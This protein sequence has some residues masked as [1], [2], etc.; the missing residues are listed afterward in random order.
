MG[1]LVIIKQ[2]LVIAILV[3][4]GYTLFRL[5]IIDEPMSKKLSTLVIDVCNPALAIACIIQDRPVVEHSKILFAGGIGIVIYLVLIAMG[6]CLPAI[7]RIAPDERKYYHMMM[8]YTNTGFIGIPLARAILPAEAMIYVIIFNVLFSLFFYTHG[9]YVLRSDALKRNHKNESEA[10][11]KKVIEDQSE[12]EDKTEKEDQS[13][14]ENKKVIAKHAI[15]SATK[16]ARKINIGIISSLIAIL[17]C[18]FN[19]RVP[20]VIGDSLIYIANA[21]TFLSMTV[22]GVS[23]AMVSFKDIFR[24]KIVYAYALLHLIVIPIII[25]KAM[26]TIGADHSMTNAFVLMTALPGANMPLMLAGKNGHDTRLLSQMILLTT[27]LSLI[28]VPAVMYTL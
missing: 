21:T 26:S 25:G 15:K 12:T 11:D 13:E 7:L 10:E 18:W 17:L 20:S 8:V 3:M 2:M 14:T 22:L 19:I 28:T 1:I 6:A 24:G 4:T 5:R 16:S 23:L 27:V 9:T